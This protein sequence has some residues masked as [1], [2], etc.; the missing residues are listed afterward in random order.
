M[1]GYFG[2]MV[3]L[4]RLT[5]WI[6]EGRQPELT[7]YDRLVRMHEEARRRGIC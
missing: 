6:I 4:N 3:D 5:H 7:T 2:S 1:H